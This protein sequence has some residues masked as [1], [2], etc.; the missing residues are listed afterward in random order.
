MATCAPSHPAGARK[1][2]LDLD[3]DEEEEEEEEGSHVESPPP[4]PAAMVTRRPTLADVVR[5]NLPPSNSL[6]PPSA[7]SES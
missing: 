3:S 4:G 2:E 6:L 5:N 1:F 7:T